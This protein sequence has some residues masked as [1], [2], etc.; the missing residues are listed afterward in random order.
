M[1]QPSMVA[2]SLLKACGRCGQALGGCDGGTEIFIARARADYLLLPRRPAQ[3]AA[4]RR[5]CAELGSWTQPHQLPL[6]YSE[7]Y[8]IRWVAEECMRCT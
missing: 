6:V 4:V 1:A 2:D 3:A 5:G 7:T 8:N